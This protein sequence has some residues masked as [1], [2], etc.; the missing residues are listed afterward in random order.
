MADLFGRERSGITKHIGNVF[1]ED[2]LDEKSNVRNLHIPFSDKPTKLYNL[3]VIISVG[4]RIK[5]QQGTRFRQW[6]TRV[7]RDHLVQGYT[8]NQSRLAEKGLSEMQQAVELLS[9]T[10]SNQ[11]LVTE[12]GQDVLSVIVGYAKTWRLLL[13]YDEDALALPPGCQPAKGV[14]GYEYAI[15]AIADLK[16]ELKCCG[17]ATDLF[18][19]EIRRDAP[20]GTL[21]R[22]FHLAVTSLSPLS[23]LS[24]FLSCLPSH[25]CT[26]AY[27]CLE[28][29]RVFP[30]SDRWFALPSNGW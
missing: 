5:S 30:S 7:L 23:H 12:A 4:Y 10:L 18:G 24:A 22:Y 6:A 26:R 21:L 16:Q 11:A 9:R 14:L 27:G 2:E 8:V 17:E 13:Q 28:Q 29:Y 19:S 1:K 20:F 3:D 25:D 15:Q